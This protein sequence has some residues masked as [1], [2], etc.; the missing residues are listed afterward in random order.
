MPDYMVEFTVKTTLGGRMV[1]NAPN[2]EEATRKTMEDE[3][4]HYNEFLEIEV[5][6]IKVLKVEVFD[7]EKNYDF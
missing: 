6:T 2:P 7:K 4:L 5:P 1:V 3:D